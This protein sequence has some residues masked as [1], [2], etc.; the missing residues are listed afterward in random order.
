MNDA[1]D[2]ST[3]F[4][5]AQAH[6]AFT[7]VAR[8]TSDPAPPDVSKQMIHVGPLVTRLLA[9]I[10]IGLPARADS[11]AAAL[12]KQGQALAPAMQPTQPTQPQTR[13]RPWLWVVLGGGGLLAGVLVT[14]LVMR[15]RAA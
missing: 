15:S 2:L 3:L 12:T 4:A 8:G 9:Q 14:V 1:G 7:V 13:T 11:V 10:G 6:P 5:Q